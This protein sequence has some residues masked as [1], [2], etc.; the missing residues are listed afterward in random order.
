MIIE[1]SKDGQHLG[2]TKIVL[3]PSQLASCNFYD[4]I[5]SYFRQIN[6]LYLGCKK[7]NHEGFDEIWTIHPHIASEPSIRIFVDDP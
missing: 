4:F 6:F 3:A 2:V 1:R 7:I 5:F